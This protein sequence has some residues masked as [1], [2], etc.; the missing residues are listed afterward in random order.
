MNGVLDHYDPFSFLVD[1][2]RDWPWHETREAAI[3]DP[4][5]QTGDRVVG[6]R[7]H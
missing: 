6:L 7:L 4:K 2:F 5:V 3:E 1:L